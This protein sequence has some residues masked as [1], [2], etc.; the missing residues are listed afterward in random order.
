MAKKPTKADPPPAE[1]TPAAPAPRI[2][3]RGRRDLWQIPTLLFAGALLIIGLTQSMRARPQT[4]FS[5]ALAAVDQLLAGEQYDDA[6]TI[7]NGPVLS[8]M[9]DPAATPAI[10]SRIYELRADAIFLQ[11]RAKKIDL[12]ANHQKI[13]ENYRTSREHQ[14]RPYDDTRIARIAETQLA[15]GM[16]D[17]ALASARKLTANPTRRHELFKALIDRGLDPGATA[18]NRA[19]A[20]DLLAELRVDP[21]ISEPLRLWTVIRQTRIS[22]RAGFPEEA[23]SRLLQEIQRLPSR[24]DPAGAEL[25]ILLGESYADLGHLD[26]ART[27]LEHASSLLD[28]A[29]ELAARAQVLLG[30]I[31]LAQGDPEQAL[32]RLSTIAERF[33]ASDTGLSAWLMKAEAEAE[34]GRHELAIASFENVVSGLGARIPGPDAPSP[35]EVDASLAQRH[36]ERFEAADLTP[37]LHY[38]ALIERLYRAV[39]PPAEALLRL[40]RTHDALGVSLLVDAPRTIDG[41]LD[42]AQADPAALEQARHHLIHAARYFERHARAV[43]IADPEASAESLWAAGDAADRAG[44]LPEAIRLYGEYAEVRADDPRALQGIFRLGRA[45]QALGNYE[46][47]AKLFERVLVDHPTSREAYASYVPL[48]QTYLLTQTPE[49]ALRAEA[50]LMKVIEGRVFGPDAPEF[51]AALIDLGAVYRQLGRY[52]EAIRRLEESLERFT[53]L[54]DDPRFLATLADARRQASDDIRGQLESAMPQSERN[55]LREIRAEHLTRALELY[56]TVIRLYQD[57]PATRLSDLDRVLLRNAFFYRGDC[58]FDLGEHEEAQAAAAGWYERAIRAYD[59]AAQRFANE[60][61]SLVAMVQI[62]NCYAALGKW[63]EVRTAH[64]RARAR[65]DELQPGAWDD[66]QAPMD[67]RYWERWLAASVEL[68]RLASGEE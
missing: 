27:H 67:R 54:R 60:P 53:D 14:D 31:D 6:I 68:D 38:A 7:L 12:P 36:R 10:L 63:R 43:V 37:A 25:F 50:L 40:A 30:R 41:A 45:R 20:L 4:D 49:N 5:G 2:P 42:I 35:A 1:A 47:A 39:D 29:S 61:A 19:R 55:S 8:A 64:Q 16:I 62:V 59:A 23:I 34:L 44:D 17:D 58:T 32:D 11:Q 52:A 28:P 48:A 15:L 46:D 9:D 26:D 22:L 56:E 13:L 66:A 18:L 3:L 57:R 24:L 51:R 33:G 21:A 65:L